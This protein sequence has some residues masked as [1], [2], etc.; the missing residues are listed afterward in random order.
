MAWPSATKKRR[1]SQVIDDV[2]EFYLL[3]LSSWRVPRFCDFQ[4]AVYFRFARSRARGARGTSNLTLR[5]PHL[6]KGN[7][8]YRLRI[9]P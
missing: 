9:A 2:A 1:C 7:V 4:P 8:V 3:V 5:I 6:G